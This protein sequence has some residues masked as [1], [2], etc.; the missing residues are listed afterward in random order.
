MVFSIAEKFLKKE[1]LFCTPFLD[2]Q[3]RGEKEKEITTVISTNSL[4]VNTN[5]T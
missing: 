3:K 1:V 4:P 5:L 2:K